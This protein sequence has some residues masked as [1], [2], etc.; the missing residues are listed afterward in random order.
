M[1]SHA[2]FK[3][4]KVLDIYCVVESLEPLGWMDCVYLTTLSIHYTNVSSIKP[5]EK[6]YT[7]RMHTLKILN[8]KIADM[9]L[10][11]I[12]M[13]KGGSLI[14]FR[15]SAIKKN[16]EIQMQDLSKIVKAEV[17]LNGV[18]VGQKLIKNRIRSKVIDRLV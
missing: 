3:N 10:S 13:R 16:E 8:N 12:R 18:R 5:L 15:M 17:R 9:G 1:L 7:L 11:Q 2:S 14:V 6:L 4:L